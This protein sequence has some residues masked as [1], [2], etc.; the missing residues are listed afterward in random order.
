MKM[1]AFGILM[2]SPIV[3]IYVLVT[4][5]LVNMHSGF[6]GFASGLSAIIMAFLLLK[7]IIEGYNS[8]HTQLSVW[9]NTGLPLV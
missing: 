5:N 9:G 8:A 2:R 1:T 4:A 6:N 3:P 7:F